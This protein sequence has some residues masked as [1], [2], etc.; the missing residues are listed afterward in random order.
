MCAS[1]IVGTMDEDKGFQS[2]K[3]LFGNFRIVPVKKHQSERGE[4]LRY[5]AQKLGWPIPRVAGKIGHLKALEDLYFI[6]S[7]ADSYEREG[8]GPWS[9]AFNGMLKTNGTNSLPSERNR[10]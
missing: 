1:G 7:A 3:D 6:K 10:P 9:K 5:F 4:L 8:K 2:A